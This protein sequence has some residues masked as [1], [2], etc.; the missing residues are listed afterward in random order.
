MDTDPIL[1]AHEEKAAARRLRFRS[2]TFLLFLASILVLAFIWLLRPSWTSADSAVTEH[3]YGDGKLQWSIADYPATVL[4]GNTFTLTL[5]DEDGKPFEGVEMI[6]KLEMLGMICGDYHFEMSETAPGVY[7]GEG[8]PLMPGL[9][10]A[11]VTIQGNDN[12]IASISR[13]FKAVY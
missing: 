3:A 13:T 7:T 10:K 9:W 8:V 6:V 5:S 4:S 2:I 11:T 1:Y 12:N